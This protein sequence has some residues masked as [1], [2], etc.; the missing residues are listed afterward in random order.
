MLLFVY[1]RLFHERPDPPCLVHL[2][3][4]KAGDMA[5]GHRDH[6]DGDVR[7]RFHMRF[8]QEP[9]IH[10]V[11]LIAG[12]DEDVR[13]RVLLDLADVLA[14]GVSR[15]LVPVR[16]FDR[17]LCRQDFDKPVVEHVELVGVRDVPVQAD[18]HELSQHVDAVDPAIEAVADRDVDQ[19]ILA[20]DRD[21]RLGPELR[22]GEQTGP[23]AAAEDQAEHGARLHG[24]ASRGRCLWRMLPDR[25]CEGKTLSPWADNYPAK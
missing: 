13:A 9:V 21:G 3:D 7:V 5:L 11:K 6:G 23:L 19:S 12:Q 15:S 1:A 24:I 10:A 8:V 22:E 17:L 14:D 20:G 2:Q 18:G 4:A 25:C 16:S